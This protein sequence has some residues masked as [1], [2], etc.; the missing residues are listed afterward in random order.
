[1]THQLPYHLRT[2]LSVAL[3]QSFYCDL[4]KTEEAQKMEQTV[5]PKRE[6]YPGGGVT[7]SRLTLLT[8]QQAN[9]STDEVLRQGILTSLG[10]LAD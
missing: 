10:W 3:P 5:R 2:I 1:M 4:D 9:E 8:A 6:D 7:G